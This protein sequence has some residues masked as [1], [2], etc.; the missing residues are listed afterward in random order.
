M[1]IDSRCIEATYEARMLVVERIDNRSVHLS[2]SGSSQLC[3][4]LTLKVSL[5]PILIKAHWI[6]EVLILRLHCEDILT[7]ALLSKQ[8]LVYL[9]VFL[10]IWATFALLTS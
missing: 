1:A 6:G 5:A 2:I 9:L 3:W 7:Q 8:V 10:L 4:Q